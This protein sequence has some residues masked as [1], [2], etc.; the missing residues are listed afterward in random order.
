[1]SL[2][3]WENNQ[4]TDPFPLQH[5]AELLYF[6]S[7]KYEHDWHST[8]HAHQCVEMFYVLKGSGSFRVED[9]M[10]PIQKDNMV[11]VN[12]GVEHTEF[13]SSQHPLEYIV[14]GMTGN[15]FLLDNQQDRRFCYLKDA[16]VTKQFLPYLNLIAEEVAKKG[17][18]YQAVVQNILQILE[19][20]LL[21]SQSAATFTPLDNLVNPKCA[22]IKRYI[23]NHYKENITI[24]TLANV[25]FLSRS[26][27]IH[28][29]TKAY[30]EPPISYLIKR[31][32]EESRYLLAKTDYSILEVGLMLGFSSGSYFSQSFRRLE[33]IGPSEYR[34][35]AQQEAKKEA[36]QLFDA[37]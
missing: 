11:I 9:I 5:S 15:E 32:V 14:L 18:R 21:R 2:L 3:R 31:R 20:Q 22:Q 27:L 25:A 8:L 17:P 7:A 26:Y 13:S 30:G 36:K 12:S 16:S 4:K 10:F 33:G 24:D 23:D 37:Y 19:I 29:F 1:M 34:R 6:S 35:R 28:I